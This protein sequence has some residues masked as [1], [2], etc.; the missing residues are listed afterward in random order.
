MDRL[1]SS[2][3]DVEVRGVA[4][5]ANAQGGVRHVLDRRLSGKAK[6][7]SLSFRNTET[8]LTF[9]AHDGRG[10]PGA[11]VSLPKVLST[12][13]GDF[14]ALSGSITAAQH[15][16]Q[17]VAT[18]HAVADASNNG[19]MSAANFS[20]LALYPGDCTTTANDSNAVKRNSGAINATQ[21]NVSG[22]KVVGAQGA[23][24]T[25]ANTAAPSAADC[26]TTINTVLARLRAH[27][28]IDT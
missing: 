16:T 7:G 25:N 27:G 9:Y 2:S 3:R 26:A 14:T 11:P 24:V 13:T 18:L 12:Y 19:F 21:Y 1:S 15:G 5:Q 28:L 20:K 6:G 23:A 8:H 17:T 22:T 4:D 10:K